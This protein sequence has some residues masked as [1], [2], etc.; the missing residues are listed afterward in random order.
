MTMNQPRKRLL[1]KGRVL[2]L[3][4]VFTMLLVGASLVAPFLLG[5]SRTAHVAYA[6]GASVTVSAAQL[7]SAKT[8]VLLTLTVTCSIPSGDMVTSASVGAQVFQVSHQQVTTGSTGT[9]FPALCDATPH[10]FPVTVG[11]GAG[12]APFHGGPATAMVNITVFFMDPSGGIS[13][14]SA[15]NGTQVIRIKG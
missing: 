1:A 15:D 11:P 14:L 4:L 7:S 3:S 12:A 8:A 6:A 9:G 2:V 13:M 5:G 10:S